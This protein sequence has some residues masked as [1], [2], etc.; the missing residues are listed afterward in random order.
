MT[1]PRRKRFDSSLPVTVPITSLGRAKISVPVPLYIP[2]ILCYIRII[3]SIISIITASHVSNKS[4][5]NALYSLGLTVS[6][7]SVASFLDH[8]DGKIARYWN[9]CSEFGIL[10]DVIADNILRGST[11]ICV[12]AASPSSS[13]SLSA[14]T[15]AT[16][17]SI[18]STYS[19]DQCDDD[20]VMKIIT[21]Y[22]PIL[23]IFLISMEWFTMFSSQML[24]IMKDKQ[25]WKDVGQQQ[26]QNDDDRHDEIETTHLVSQHS[27]NN[28]IPIKGNK[29]A[30][31]I[32]NT[33]STDTVENPTAPPPPPKFVQAV[34]ANNFCNFFGILAMYGLFS[35]GM[36]TFLYIHKCLM[37]QSIPLLRIPLYVSLTLSYIGRFIALCTEMWLC[38]EYM[39]MILLLDEE[40]KKTRG[41]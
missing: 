9:Q 6:I 31:T 32:N 3:L 1:K 5:D 14:S 8:I 37:L 13:T 11:W 18:V 7:W 19:E 27:E 20:Y 17:S 4:N 24:K 35:I 2:N 36:I 15:A 33:T 40:N 23:G 16:T 38:G 30:S 25:H 21:T 34:F 22:A 10:L 28:Q 26:K 41:K 12:I 29:V 39:K